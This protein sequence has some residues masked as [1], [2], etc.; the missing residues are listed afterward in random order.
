MSGA[1]DYS[2]KS[3][4]RIDN[5]R[6]LREKKNK[7]GEKVTQIRGGRH[8]GGRNIYFRRCVPSHFLMEDRDYALFS[9]FE[10]DFEPKPTESLEKEALLTP[11]RYQATRNV[12]WY[13]ET[14]EQGGASEAVLKKID[15]YNAEVFFKSFKYQSMDYAVPQ[16]MEDDR[17]RRHEVRSNLLDIYT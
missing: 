15:S 5:Y 8:V 12:E 10:D 7:E 3:W 1:D 9:T 11:L 17:V 2:K 4:K 16:I 6:L 14:F 13:Y